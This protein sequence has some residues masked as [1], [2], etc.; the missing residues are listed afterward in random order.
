MGCTATT[1]HFSVDFCLKG[2]C[3]LKQAIRLKPSWLHVC[4]QNAILTKIATSKGNE[5]VQR[6]QLGIIVV[7]DLLSEV[8]AMPEQFA[9]LGA[10]I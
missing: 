4:C 1:H 8:Q 2:G 3:D 9:E 10:A 5:H 6:Q 7:V